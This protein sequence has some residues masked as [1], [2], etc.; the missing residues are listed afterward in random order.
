[1]K[2]KWIKLYKTVC[3]FLILS[4]I[5]G[6]VGRSLAEASPE[7][8]VA[9]TE[10]GQ[11]TVLVGGMQVGIYMET[12]G[13]LVLDTQKIENEEGNFCEPAHNLLHAGDYIL[14]MNGAKVLDKDALIREVEKLTSSEVRMKIKRNEELIEVKFDAVKTNEEEYKLGVWVRDNV[15]G[16]GTITYLT[17]NSE[18]GALGHGIHDVDISSLIDISKGSLYKTNIGSIKKGETGNPGSMEGIIIYNSLNKIG[19]IYKNTEAGIYGELENIEEVFTE[20]YAVEVAKAEEIKT[21]PAKIRCSL[22][23][24]IEEYDIEILKVDLWQK[25]I[26][27]GIVINVTDEEL[28]EKTGGIIQG[29]SGSPILQD[30]KLI[31]A[32][33]HVFVNDPTKGYGIFIENMLEAAG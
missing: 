16:L 6:S 31:G 13:I 21:G 23:D 5:S 15:Q 19:T 25:E 24:E 20:K 3:L 2:N 7:K 1:M 27:K 4:V 22:G 11:D 10:V 8:E 17:Q 26:N 28:L 18:F 9:T 12:D 32:V 33:T 29:M 30:G 14:E